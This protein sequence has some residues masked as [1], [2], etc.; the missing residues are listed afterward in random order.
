MNLFK[1]SLSAALSAGLIL[2]AL[3]SCC[4][5]AYAEERDVNV[6]SKIAVIY[7]GDVQCSI[8]NYAKLSAYVAKRQSEGYTTVLAD[9][10]DFASGDDIGE[11]LRGE[12]IVSIMD[13]L[14]SDGSGYTVVT[15]GDHDFDYGIDQL[16]NLTTLPLFRTI[17]SNFVDKDGNC[18]F[19]PW[20]MID[21]GYTQVAFVG[22]TTPET[23]TDSNYYRFLGENDE[24]AYSFCRDDEN[25]GA[26]F[27][28]NV[29]NSV[30]AAKNAGA[31]V[32]IALSHLGTSTNH[33]LYSSKSV[34]NNTTGI[35]ICIDANQDNS[36]YSRSTVKNQNAENVTLI[37]PG[38]KLSNLCE[39]TIE[40]GQITYNSQATSSYFVPTNEDSDEYSAYYSVKDT[41]DT[42]K[43]DYS[44]RE[45]SVVL[46][47]DFNLLKNNPTNINNITA[48]YKETNLGDFCADAYRKIYETDIGLIRGA[49]IAKNIP[50]GEITY[51]QLMEV[52]PTKSPM[53][54]IEATGQE[55]IDALEFSVASNPKSSKDF[56]QVSG[57]T[58]EIHNYIP[59]SVKTNADGQF[60]SVDGDY[61]VKNVMVGG[62]PIDP[63]LTYTIASD[64][65]ML[66]AKNTSYTMFLDNTIIKSE[67]KTDADT[68][69]EFA[70]SELVGTVDDI[71]ENLDGM[72]RINVIS[73]QNTC[74]E[75]LMW[76]FDKETGVLTI[77]GE[78]YS[79]EYFNT[80]APWK[81]NVN[82]ITS[83]VIP[84]DAAVDPNAFIGCKNLK[85]I[86]FGEKVYLPGD[87]NMSGNYDFL[88]LVVISKALISQANSHWNNILLMDYN[89]SGG[90]DFLD[91]V[92]ISKE[93]LNANKK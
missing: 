49:N 67:S 30:D 41:I 62:D 9:A 10:G 33:G 13:E 70:E 34:I 52:L 82:D 57:I 25:N 84:E 29:Q 75:N 35:N 90:V 1:K 19:D 27:Y 43:A 56:L 76:S 54:I 37:T 31:D 83:V 79:F 18:V 45:N 86:V 21:D 55:I 65:D 38:Q 59:S 2:S 47:S 85:S 92:G 63:E 68:L 26:A 64:S 71:Y 46:Q 93:L 60:E 72:G 42:I 69:L 48:R 78:G 15:P 36:Q 89:H 20:T 22:I 81:S 4:T 44:E 6:D 11:Y 73:E 88:D 24:Y 7:T 74:G 8:N 80:D 53:C 66:K 17:S 50:E 14:G 91:L 77:S 23:I 40:N 32:V 58:Y 5:A 3:S 61:R 16:K 28:A 87:A 51:K 39:I 12:N